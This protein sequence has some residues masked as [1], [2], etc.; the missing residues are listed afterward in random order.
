[1]FQ[2]KSIGASGRDERVLVIL[3]LGDPGLDGV[4]I[5]V[6]GSVIEKDLPYFVGDVI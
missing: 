3:V 1:M 5:R 4:G 2:S 6:D